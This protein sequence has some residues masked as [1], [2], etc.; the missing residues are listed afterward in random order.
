MHRRLIINQVALLSWLL[1]VRHLCEAR[2]GPVHAVSVQAAH[3]I[4]GGGLAA[5][6]LQVLERDREYRIHVYKCSIVDDDGGS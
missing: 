4:I 5:A 3:E 6:M 1:L 2:L